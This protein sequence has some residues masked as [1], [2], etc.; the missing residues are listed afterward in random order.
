MPSISSVRAGISAIV[1]T[2]VISSGLFVWCQQ[3]SSQ[4]SPRELF[5]REQL[6]EHH[7]RVPATP[8][9]SHPVSGQTAGAQKVPGN[10]AISP[11]PPEVNSAALVE[12]SS[13]TKASPEVSH[14]G[15]R[16]RLLSVDK[17]TGDT[18]PVSSSQMFEQGDCFSLEFE[19]NRSGYLYVFNL[20]SSG[21]WRPL[22]PRVEMPEEINFVPAFTTQRVPSSHCFRISGPPGE[23]H[24]FVVL[25]RNPQEVDELNQSIRNGSTGESAPSHP[26]ATPAGTMMMASNLNQAVQKI[27][28]LKGRDLEIQE[29]GGI[30]N[31]AENTPAVYV[32][33]TSTAPTDKVVTE[34]QIKHR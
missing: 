15:L 32:V 20:G 19:S 4:L 34:I 6:S 5:Y 9:K 23:E 18:T 21:A 25:S 22:L 8:A 27:A 10:P 11:G 7:Q 1:V 33:H 12:T 31:S 13:A 14:L 26:S 2:G 30:K 16:Y 29:V 3:P 17:A 28:S 24:L